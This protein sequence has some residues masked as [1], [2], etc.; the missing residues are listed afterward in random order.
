M[1][2]LNSV[3]EAC[4]TS[5]ETEAFFII[6]GTCLDQ[7]ISQDI[8]L[9]KEDKIKLKLAACIKVFTVVFKWLINRVDFF[10]LSKSASP[11]LLAEIA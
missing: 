6:L 7:I 9:I 11:E 5:Q 4:L 2:L 1:T 10:L 3:F 8:L